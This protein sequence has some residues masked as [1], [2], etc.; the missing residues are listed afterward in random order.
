V[1]L[2]GTAPICAS[3]VSEYSCCRIHRY[4]AAPFYSTLVSFQAY[5]QAHLE[6]IKGFGMHGYEIEFESLVE[7]YQVNAYLYMMAIRVE[8]F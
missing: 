6:A 2:F 1:H 8:R 3:T 4:V 5:H 7:E